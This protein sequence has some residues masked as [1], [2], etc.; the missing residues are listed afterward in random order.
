[1]EF[2]KCFNVLDPL[3]HVQLF[4]QTFGFSRWFRQSAASGWVWTSEAAIKKA[5]VTDRGNALAGAQDLPDLE[6][7]D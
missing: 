3:Q 5:L 6:M 7:H 4:F 2:F 1:M